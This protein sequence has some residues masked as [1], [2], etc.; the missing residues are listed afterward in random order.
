MRRQAAKVLND[1]SLHNQFHTS[2]I[3]FFNIKTTTMK[4]TLTLIS[5]SLLLLTSACRR[6]EGN[7]NTR[8]ENRTVGA[9]K[10]V[11]SRGSFDVYVQNSASSSLSI[12]ADENLLPY[13]EA[14]VRGDELQ[15]SFKKGLSYDSENPINIYVAAPEIN[16]F[17]LAGSGD[18]ISQSSISSKGKLIF[19]IRGS[20][21]VKA[22]VDAPSVESEVAGSGNISLSGFTKDFSATVKGAGNINCFDLKTENTNIEVS[23]SGDAEVYASVSV[24]ATIRGAGSVLHKGNG[25]VTKSE[26]HGSG[27]ISKAN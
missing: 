7:G 14:E 15:I 21:N 5:L 20:G 19:S 3:S 23:G 25:V 12:E 26:I 13:I 11:S 22:T 18:I 8:K 2:L 9:F 1:Q 16:E 17:E 6:I 27:S 4:Q 24:A 10:A